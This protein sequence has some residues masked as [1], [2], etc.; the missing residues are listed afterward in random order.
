LTEEELVRNYPRL[1]HMARDGAWPAIRDHG[2]MS[3]AALLDAYGVAGNERTTLITERRRGSVPLVRP[4]LPGAVLR[5]QRPMRDSGLERSPKD[6]LKPADWYELLNSRSF[7]WLSRTRVLGLLSAKAYRREPH[8]VLTLDTKSIVSAHRARIWL[9]PLNSGSTLFSAGPHGR[10]TS[11]RI[12]DF[13]FEAR[14]ATRR[15]AENVVE[16]LVEHSVPDVRDHV[17]AVHRVFD[18]KILKEVW[19]DPLTGDDDRP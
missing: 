18:Q 9:S 13:P 10:D 3:S 12:P 14:A 2:L 6:G 15:P 16:L 11:A 7:F 17:L 5:D 19:R 8:T 1:W 4:G